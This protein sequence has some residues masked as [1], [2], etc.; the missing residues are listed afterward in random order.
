[1]SGG[2]QCD[3]KL[4]RVEVGLT[5]TKALIRKVSKDNNYPSIL[6]NDSIIFFEVTIRGMLILSTSN[7]LLIS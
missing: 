4:E 5:M 7:Q 1:M 3:V 6:H 2:G